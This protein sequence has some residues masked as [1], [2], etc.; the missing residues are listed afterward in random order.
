M[1]EAMLEIP[2]KARLD[3]CPI[4]GCGV[5]VFHDWAYGTRPLCTE[6]GCTIQGAEFG[7]PDD[8][9]E[10]LDEAREAAAYR[11]NSRPRPTQEQAAEF[12]ALQYTIHCSKLVD[13]LRADDKAGVDEALERSNIWKA[14]LQEIA[15]DHPFLRE[16]ASEPPSEPR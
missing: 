6:C 5:V 13:A 9:C 16:T 2:I 8:G 11:W 10:T 12:L 4:C 1:G 14:A 3:P 7:S 15:P